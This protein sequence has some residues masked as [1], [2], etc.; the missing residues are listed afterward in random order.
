MSVSEKE[1]KKKEDVTISASKPMIRKVES[2]EDDSDF[3]CYKLDG[4]PVHVDIDNEV[5]EEDGHW[6]YYQTNWRKRR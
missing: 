4:K 2:D 1:T 6:H 3:E 5:T